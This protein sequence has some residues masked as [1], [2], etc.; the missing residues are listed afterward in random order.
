MNFDTLITEVVAGSTPE[1]ALE[2]F[3]RGLLTRLASAD[4]EDAPAKH[5]C[6]CGME[7]PVYPGRYPSVCPVCGRAITP[8]E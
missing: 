1:Q 5:T 2:K 7:I 6:K 4:Q 8:K 3:T